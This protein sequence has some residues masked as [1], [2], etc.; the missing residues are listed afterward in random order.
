MQ[1]LNVV[2]N[3]SKS[4]TLTIEDSGSPVDISD[5]TIYFTVK[6]NSNQADAQALISKTVT[7]H[8]EPL[9]GKTIISLTPTDTDIAPGTY[10]YNINYLTGVGVIQQA[11]VPKQFTVIPNLKGV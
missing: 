10:L 3:T 8:T 9:Q 7:I 1:D 11:T 2:R 5:Y 6:K 4:Y